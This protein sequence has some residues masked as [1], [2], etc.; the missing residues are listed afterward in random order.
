MRRR[1]LHDRILPL[2]PARQSVSPR[3]RRTAP[4]ENAECLLAVRR[5]GR[6]LHRRV[7]PC[8]SAYQHPMGAWSPRST[9]ASVAPSRDPGSVGWLE[10]CSGDHEWCRRVRRANRR[11]PRPLPQGTRS[12]QR[13]MVDRRITHRDPLR[14]RRRRAE[15]DDTGQGPR[16]EL[17]FHTQLAAYARKRPNR[18]FGPWIVSSSRREPASNP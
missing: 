4:F 8:A 16:E 12:A 17:A 18:P 2:T 5:T 14:A 3:A 7:R 11:P 13:R 9:S 15:I 6:R 10:P 1:V